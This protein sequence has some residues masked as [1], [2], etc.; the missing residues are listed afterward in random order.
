M[1][2]LVLMLLKV[3]VVVDVV[4]VKDR[5]SIG[6]RVRVRSCCFMSICLRGFVEVCFMC[7]LI[8]LGVVYV[9]VVIGI[10]YLVGV[11]VFW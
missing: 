8:I 11:M 7:C 3:S 9:D 10:G 4:V 6:V 1:K 5:V 2:L